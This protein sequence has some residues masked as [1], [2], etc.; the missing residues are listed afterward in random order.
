MGSLMTGGAVV[1]SLMHYVVGRDCSA[2]S[3]RRSTLWPPVQL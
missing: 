3:A 2:V 1:Y